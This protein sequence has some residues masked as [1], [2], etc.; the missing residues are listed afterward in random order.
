[1]KSVSSMRSFLSDPISKSKKLTN[2]FPSN[3]VNDEDEKP[4][5]NSKEFSQNFEIELNDNILSF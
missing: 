4:I 1:M 3:N 5:K 2:S